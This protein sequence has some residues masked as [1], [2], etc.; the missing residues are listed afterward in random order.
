MGGSSVSHK[1][2]PE[3]LFPNCL[4]D[5][6]GLKFMWAIYDLL[7]RTS[8]IKESWIKS[9]RHG[10]PGSVC[11]CWHK[12]GLGSGRATC[13]SPSD[14]KC[15]S[16][17]LNILWAP[18]LWCSASVTQSNASSTFRY[19]WSLRLESQRDRG[20]GGGP[21]LQDLLGALWC[22]MS[23]TQERNFRAYSLS[24]SVTAME[25]ARE[26]HRSK[27]P[28]QDAG[29][30]PQLAFNKIMKMNF[31]HEYSQGVVINSCPIVP[32]CT[33]TLHVATQR[34]PNI[35]KETNFGQDGL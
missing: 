8:W 35:A 26:K 31:T 15:D 27:T 17:D 25:R 2:V 9:G 22:A 16:A 6:A 14:S 3:T 30:L 1:G 13:S 23:L 24:L 12:C 11:T 10:S 28:M 29:H 21:R 7:S 33:N 20:P 5:S 4:V 18:S 32:Y 19:L 34:S